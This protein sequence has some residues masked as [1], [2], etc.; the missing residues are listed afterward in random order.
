MEELRREREHQ[1][2]DDD[3]HFDP[4]DRPRRAKADYCRSSMGETKTYNIQNTNLV[5]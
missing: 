3:A 5:D 2:V 4:A 1:P